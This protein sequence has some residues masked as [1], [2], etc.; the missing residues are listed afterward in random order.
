MDGA[1]QDFRPID[2][3]EHELLVVDDDPASRY[4][5]ARLLRSAGFRTREAANGAEGLRVAEVGG[6]SA[7]IIDVHLP[8][9]DGFELCRI[10]RS[11]AQ[12]HR[13]PVLHLSAA[14]VTDEDKVRGLDSGADAYLTHPVEPAVLVATVQALVRTHV[15]EEAMR[16]SESKFRAVY[17]QAPSGI[18]LLDDTN[19]V[20]D[21]NPAMLRMLAR[22]ASEVVGHPVSDF[23][24]AACHADAERLVTHVHGADA[25]REF[26]LL[27]PDGR[28]A[29]LEWNVS[30]QIEP[31]VNLVVASDVSQR[32]ALERQRQQMLDR[33]RMAR[34]EAEKVNRMKD[35]FIAVLSHE[36]RAPLNAI[37]GWTYV[38]QKRGGNEDTLR[39]LSAIE[40]NG[41]IQAR[42]I[43]DLLD[44]SRL[45]LGKLP[46]SIDQVAPAEAAAAAVSAMRPAIEERDVEVRM[47]V[48]ASLRPIHADSS[49]LQQVIWNLLSN[50]IKFSPR[51]G[52]I[53]LAVRQDAQDTIFSVRDE[54]QG[55]APEFLP[56]VFD[57]FMQSDAGKNRHQGGLGLGLSIVKQ[58]VEAHGGA[59]SAASEGIGRGSTFEV[60]LPLES[61]LSDA[62]SDDLETNGAADAEESGPSE[63]GVGD[64]ADATLAGIR[65]LVVDDDS[66]ATGMLQII[67]S[68]RG[69]TVRTAH[70]Y[71]EA[72]TT[73]NAASA[74]VLI[75]DIGM[76]GKDGY[77]LIREVRRREL[78][79][80]RHLPAV[81]LTSFT[82]REDV[83]QA[84]AAGFDAHCA[85]P[86]RP[87]KLVRLIQQLIDRRG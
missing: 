48:Q 87:L 42:M 83:D 20:I 69:A 45:N 77:D 33:E 60:R 46:L 4:A 86:L 47:D 79:T 74:D 54:G 59:V 5:T 85:K 24:P 50:A 43:S 7:M 51:G 58:L 53:D 12:T 72:L 40:R 9:I 56:Y 18:A 55:I 16:R 21:A 23:V 39:G 15:A 11:R 66:D 73:L 36:L 32:A 29:L 37:M 44:M 8:D 76:P 28:E 3:S 31:G 26:P 81:A 19:R 65:A 68:D 63:M 6:L 61:P 34:G 57:R 10:L 1:N 35:T 49:R 17:E 82:R 84:M 30:P 80:R 52:M 62:R 22:T 38:L 75:S 70:D 41:H 13:L 67:L 71:R 27:T 78:L 64:A 2:R 14:Y 25:A